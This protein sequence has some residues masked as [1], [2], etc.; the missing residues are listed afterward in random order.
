MADGPLRGVRILDLTHVWSGPLS[1]RILADLGAETVRIEAPD[2]RGPRHFPEYGALGGWIG[3]SP[4]EDP[5]NRVAVIVKLQRN[6]RSLAIDLKCRAGRQAF[7]DLVAVADV[8]MENFSTD[9]LAGLGLGYDALCAANPGII[10]M[11]MPG[12]G[13]EGPYR[14]RVAFGPTVEAMSGLTQVMG[15]GPD[16]PRNSATA[17]MDPVASLNA[18]GAIVTALR[19]R[20]ATGEGSFVEMA[21]HESGVAFC[22]PW[23]VEQQLGGVAARIGNAHPAMSPHGVYACSGEDAWVAMAC[24]DDTDWRRL[25]CLIGNGLQKEWPLAQRRAHGASID[26]TISSWTA[27]RSKCDAA[28]LLQAAGIPAG[29]VNTTPDMVA[30]PQVRERQFF[31]PL[32]PGPTPVPGNP[33]KMNGISSED[34][35]PCP[36]L[37]ADNAAV[38]RDWL[39]WEEQQVLALQRAGALADRPPR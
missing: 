37:G 19:H 7:L 32:E 28:M 33:I 14:D 34:W 29:P 20:Q 3:G 10:Y 8:V 27:T 21:L 25:C 2:S 15:Y 5:W 30:D 26:A 18:A 1:T 23:L 16:E 31:V 36:G 39:G 11:A 24:R 9:T 22:G 38:L 13:L 4:G 6:K 17:L 12:F 35:T